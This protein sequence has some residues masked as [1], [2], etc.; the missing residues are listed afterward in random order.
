MFRKIMLIALICGDCF[1]MSPSEQFLNFIN[2]NKSNIAT[3]KG[4]LQQKAN[5]D[6]C[7]FKSVAATFLVKYNNCFDSEVVPEIGT[8]YSAST[9]Y[10]AAQLIG[11]AYLEKGMIESQKTSLEKAL[12]WFKSI[13]VSFQ[14]VDISPTASDSCVVDYR[15]TIESELRRI[16]EQNTKLQQL[17]QQAEGVF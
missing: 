11:I 6:S 17:K 2:K 8:G 5:D 7:P 16:T 9:F 13:P 1:A 15:Q 10:T 4:E 12:A 3:L 14:Q